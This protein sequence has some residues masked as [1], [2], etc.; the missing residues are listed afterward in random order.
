MQAP[1]GVAF[2]QSALL[3]R[4]HPLAHRMPRDPE[5]LRKLG[6]CRQRFAGLQRAVQDRL[7]QRLLH[8]LTGSGDLEA[9]KRHAISF[10]QQSNI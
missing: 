1:A 2:Y 10:V 6:L 8:R 4:P 9:G 5:L 7:F 3:K